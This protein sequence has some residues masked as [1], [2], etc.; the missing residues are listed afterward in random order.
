MSSVSVTSSYLAPREAYLASVPATHGLTLSKMTKALVLAGALTLASEVPA[1]TLGFIQEEGKLTIDE[2]NYGKSLVSVSVRAAFDTVAPQW[3]NTS[4]CTITGTIGIRNVRTSEDP[5]TLGEDFNI[6]KN[7]FSMTTRPRMVGEQVQIDSV[8]DEVIFEIL[9]DGDEQEQTESIGFEISSYGV[10][11]DDGSVRSFSLGYGQGYG[12]GTIIINDPFDEEEAPAPEAPI[13]QPSRAIPVRQK[14]LSSQLNSLRTL[15]LHTS[16]TRDRGIAK[17]I[18]RARNRGGFSSDNFQIKVAGQSLPVG[19]LLGAGAGDAFDD[20]GRFGL[21]VSGSIDAGELDKDA[22]DNL[23][24]DSSQLIIGLD[25]RLTDKII[26]GGAVSQTEAG[27]GE[28]E[29]AKTDA[30]RS[31]LSLFGSYYSNDA[32]Y[33]DAIL[34]YGA[35]NYDLDRTIEADTGNPDS[36]VADTDGDE[37][38]ASVGAGYNIHKSNINLRLFSFVNYIDANIDGYQESVSGLSSAAQVDGVDLQSLTADAGLEL[39]WNINS[40]VG[41][42]T[43]T[44]ALAYQRQFKDDAVD[45]TGSFIGGLDEGNFYY[46]APAR[47]DNYLSARSGVSAVLPNGISAYITYDTYLRRDDFSSDYVS[48]GARWE[49]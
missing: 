16:G 35:S 19:A 2:P 49:F 43:P 1:A 20:F 5:A 31:S 18:N 37:T 41:V 7:T 38:S 23:D 6:L 27:A 10:V 32:F 13:V 4:S 34:S 26:L 45:I 29:Y 8:S 47:D 17:E 15:T 25:Y 21:F 24:F 14:S 3:Q 36:A 39:S 46:Q 40:K 11:C 22:V 44:L 33:V 9:D 42:F 12:Y 28:M 30:S 48:L